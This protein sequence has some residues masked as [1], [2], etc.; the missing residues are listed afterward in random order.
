[1]ER[2]NVNVCLLDG[3]KGVEQMGCLSGQGSDTIPAYGAQRVQRWI[4]VP[5]WEPVHARSHLLFSLHHLF[6]IEIRELCSILN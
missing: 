2:G 3:Q 5:S 1:M 6:T 4:N